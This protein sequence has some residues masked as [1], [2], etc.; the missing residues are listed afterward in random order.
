MMVINL[1]NQIF[2]VL[3][4][5]ALLSSAACSKKD[6]HPEDDDGAA[7]SAKAASIEASAKLCVAQAFND[8]AEGILSGS[9][10]STDEIETL[11]NCDTVKTASAAVTPADTFEVSR[12]T[13]IATC[14]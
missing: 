8:C 1:K 4:I 9:N 11:A 12:Q 10:L 5:A 2:M 3:A 14:L 6:G 7:P 13:V